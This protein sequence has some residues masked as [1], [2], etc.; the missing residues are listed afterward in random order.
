MTDKNSAQI[1]SYYFPAW[2]SIKNLVNGTPVS[3][4]LYSGH[5]SMIFRFKADLR[6]SLLSRDLESAVERGLQRISVND[7]GFIDLYFLIKSDSPY[8]GND[9][10]FN[11]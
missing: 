11:Y 9:I 8:F 7:A 4:F 2:G 6:F 5:D 10:Q 3:V 1:L